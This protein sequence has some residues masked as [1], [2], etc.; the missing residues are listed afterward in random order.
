M[1]DSQPNLGLS[2]FLQTTPEPI[3]LGAIEVVRHDSLSPSQFQKLKHFA[4]YFEAVAWIAIVSN[5]LLGICSNSVI[6]QKFTLLLQ[7]VF[8]HVYVYTEYL[9]A[10]FVWVVGSGLQRMQNLNYFSTAAADAI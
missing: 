9:P 1:H 4:G 10:S 2:R 6:T 8:L 7:I 3:L 5:L